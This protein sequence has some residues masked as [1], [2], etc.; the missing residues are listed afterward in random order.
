MKSDGVNDWLR[1]W[2][3]LQNRG[4]RPLVLKDSSDK[5]PTT[6]A[7]IPALMSTQRKCKGKARYIEPDESDTA[8]KTDREMDGN[9]N[10]GSPPDDPAHDSAPGAGGASPTSTPS[11]A[12][13]GP[14]LPPTPAS[15]ALT[16]KSRLAFLTSLSEDLNYQR[17]IVL[18]CAAKVGVMLRRV[19]VVDPFARMETFWK[20]RRH[21]GHP[22]HLWADTCPMNFMTPCHHLPFPPSV[23]GPRRTQSQRME[24]YLRHMSKWSWS[25]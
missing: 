18:L 4:K 7:S 25:S 13:N 14:L 21:H 17:L 9:K 2:L 24:T 20:D 12:N 16:R 8:E 6:R 23:T 3:Q 1:Y 19:S 22:G 15:A 11:V 10:V 5:S